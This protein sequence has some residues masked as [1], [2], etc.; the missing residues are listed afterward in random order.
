[1]SKVDYLSSEEITASLRKRET[2]RGMQHACVVYDMF[3][4]LQAFPKCDFSYS[5]AAV[6]KISTKIARRAVPL[7]LAQSANACLHRFF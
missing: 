3:N 5:C 1:M 4:H 2:S 7:L 6:D